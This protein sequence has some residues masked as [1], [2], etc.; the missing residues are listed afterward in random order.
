MAQYYYRKPEPD[1]I[2]AKEYFEKAIL[3][4]PNQIDTL[5]F[6]SLYDIEDGKLDEAREKLNHA[7]EGNFSPLNF[8][9]KD[10]IKELLKSINN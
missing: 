10:K 7:L 4:R 9:Q 2:K 8:A 5:Y 6:L 1:T 3:I